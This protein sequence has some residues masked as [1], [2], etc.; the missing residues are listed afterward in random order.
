MVTD[1]VLA[2][3]L[4]YGSK[5]LHQDW[6]KYG[7]MFLVFAAFQSQIQTMVNGVTKGFGSTTTSSGNTANAG[8]AQGDS[9]AETPASVERWLRS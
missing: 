6:M 5:K 7:A 1:L 4:G 9:I 2:A 8:L 3:L